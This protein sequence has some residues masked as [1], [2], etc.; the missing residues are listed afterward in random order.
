[1]ERMWR[2]REVA[3]L[4]R[5]H[6]ATVNEWIRQGRI[7]AVRVGKLWRIPDSEVKRIVERG[8]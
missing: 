3:E 4:L 7:R 1:M 6:R 5:V 2:V 8:V